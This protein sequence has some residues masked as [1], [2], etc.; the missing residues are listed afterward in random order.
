VTPRVAV[1]ACL[2]G[3]PVRYDGGRRPAEDLMEWLSRWAEP[4]GICPEVAAGLGVPR[5]PIQVE[6][7]GRVVGVSSRTDH[8]AALAA[9]APP[10]GVSGAVLQARSPSCGVGST[11][12]WGGGA[13]V[14]TGDGVFAGSLRVAGL[15]VAD[16]V[17]LESSEA[18]DAFRLAVLATA[19]AS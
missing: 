2:L 19:S 9:I 1:S 6:V 4:V 13:V 11:P 18:R 7:D 15:P 17:G 8:T 5:E 3:E 12:I 16:R 10:A 14:A